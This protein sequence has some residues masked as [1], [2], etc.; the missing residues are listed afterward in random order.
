MPIV[1]KNNAYNPFGCDDGSYS[2]VVREILEKVGT[3]FDKKPYLMWSF[4]IEDPMR[5]GEFVEEEVV[6]SATTSMVPVDGQK[7]DKWLK[8]CGFDLDDGDQFDTDAA[9]GKRVQVILE[10]KKDTNNGMVYC[11]VANVIQI[12][13]KSPRPITEGK[14][15]PKL[16]ERVREAV[17]AEI[18]DS[19]AE[20]IIEEVATKQREAAE[21]G[22]VKSKVGTAT[23][24]HKPKRVAEPIPDDE[25]NLHEGFEDNDSPEKEDEDVPF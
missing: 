6:V 10:N 14:P 20:A 2:A 1:Q 8:A 12:K 19:E 25:T 17:D 18:S 13:R 24:T 7:L 15:K 21:K 5:D 3:K 4:L 23:I 16:M 9:V 22:G 11:R